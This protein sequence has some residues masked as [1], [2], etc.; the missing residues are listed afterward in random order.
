MKMHA[1]RDAI[2]RTSGA[3]VLYPGGNESPPRHR[4]YHEILPGLG[5]FVMRPTEDGEMAHET[6]G[7]LRR[8]LDDVLSHTAA[9][10]T[11]Q[12][13]ADYWT[14][15]AYRE[16]G[17]RLRFNDDLSKPAADTKV[18]LAY[19]K[20][21]EHLAWIQRNLLYN[22]RA[23]GRKGSIG[24]TSPELGSDLVILYRPTWT[25]PL[26]LRTT[27]AFVLKDRGALA[28]SGYPNPRSDSYLCLALMEEAVETPI[29]L[30]AEVIM[31]RARSGRSRTN[32]AAP[33]TTSW[34]EL[35]AESSVR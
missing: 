5:A 6:E 29:G 9:G 15:T 25:T 17:Q 30:T 7:S 26:V 23:D 24:L 1:Y 4:Q 33:M 32:W 31:Q 18:L 21:D 11:S 14:Q 19:V 13:R 16:P 34:A 20:S 8:F 2:R 3:Y 10:G 12:E 22:M 28:A 35:V 27:G